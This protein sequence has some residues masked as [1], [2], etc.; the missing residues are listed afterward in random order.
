MY[1]PIT[2]NKELNVHTYYR[3]QRN[4]IY[5]PITENKELNVHT[6]LRKAPKEYYSKLNPKNITDNKRFWRTVKPLFSD[7][8]IGKETIILVD[9][10]EI[11]Q[12]ELVVAEKFSE[13]FSNAV[14]NW[15]FNLNMAI[16]SPTLLILILF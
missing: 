15:R 3:K 8:S 10:D 2:E 14:K 11:F 12:D 5:I 9:K 4:S 6:Y 7:K 13:F 16:L 1:I